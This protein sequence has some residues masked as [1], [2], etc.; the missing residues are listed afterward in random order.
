VGEAV[1]RFIGEHIHSVHQLEVLLLLRRT[2]PRA[3]SAAQVAAELRTTGPS[4]AAD[5]T[6]LT[7]QS[8]LAEQGGDAASYVYAPAPAGLELVVA[9]LDKTYAERHL[10]I[11]KL[12]FARP[13][14]AP[15]MR[16]FSDALRLRR[17]DEPRRS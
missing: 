12:I 13:D 7:A 2:Q 3:W 17:K 15:A 4:A 11:I 5:L 16:A 10:S 6:D 8:L 1:A 9:D 14:E